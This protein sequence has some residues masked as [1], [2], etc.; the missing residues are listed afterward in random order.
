[1]EW[2]GVM[3]LWSE[4]WVAIPLVLVLGMHSGGII[5]LRLAT[6]CTGWGTFGEMLAKADQCLCCAWGYL[7]KALM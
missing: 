2:V 3:G 7:G 4:L 6:A 1:M 5:E